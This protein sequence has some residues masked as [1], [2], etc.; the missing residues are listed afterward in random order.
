MNKIVGRTFNY[1][2]NKCLCENKDS[3]INHIKKELLWDVN[4]YS[5]K[6]VNRYLKAEAKKL[7]GRK[8]VWIIKTKDNRI[9]IT[10]TKEN[11]NPLVVDVKNIKRGKPLLCLCMCDHIYFHQY[12]YK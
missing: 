10:H 3:D 4:N 5:I 8:L 11:E 2:F 6:D 9:M 1:F 7:K 12:Y